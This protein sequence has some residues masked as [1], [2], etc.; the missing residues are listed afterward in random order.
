M[1]P[2]TTVLL[3]LLVGTALTGWGEEL[4]LTLQPDKCQIHFTL[5][6]TLHTVH[7]EMALDEGSIT[8]DP[9][10][11][12]ANGKIVIDATRTVTGNGKRDHKMHAEVLESARFPSIVFSVSAVQGRLEQEGASELQL[13]GTVSV[14]GASHAVSFPAHVVR[15]GDQISATATV[16]VPFVEW[17]MQDPSVFVF[18]VDKQVLVDLEVRGPLS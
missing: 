17:G 14:H 7:G 13:S 11:G 3:L 6:S 9:T 2:R 18:R 15:T 1:R 12:V 4:V 16:T 10:T 5:D 8:F